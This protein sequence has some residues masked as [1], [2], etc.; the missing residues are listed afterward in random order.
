M[1][2]SDVGDVMKNVIWEKSKESKMMR[3]P[4]KSAIINNA[5][6][7][8]YMKKYGHIHDKKESEK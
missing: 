1:Q 4:P 7:K 5:G 2:L 6:R 8:K 3:K